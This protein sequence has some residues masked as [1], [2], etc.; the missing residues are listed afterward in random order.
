MNFKLVFLFCF[1]LII[2]FDLFA[3]NFENFEI[4][5]ENEIYI[6]EFVLVN[7][8]TISQLYLISE[9][10]LF[11]LSD[12]ASTFEV[13]PTNEYLVNSIR[14]RPSKYRTQKNTNKPTKYIELQGGYLREPNFLLLQPTQK[15]K[16]TFLIEPK[17]FN[18]LNAMFTYDIFINIHHC[19]YKKFT[20]NNNELRK[21]ILTD[22]FT[23]NLV[24]KI[25][26]SFYSNY[27]SF[28]EIYSDKK[29]YF[30]D[31]F[32]NEYLQVYKLSFK[33]ADIK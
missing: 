9:W 20:I 5:K 7:K 2:V 19:S 33:I 26:R 24:F 1:V 14:I 28:G 32:F 15:Q 25:Y 11:S 12:T 16:I 21:K 22:D 8:D 17:V 29:K 4:R 3:T 10:N 23:S 31:N 30:L 18:N 13:I 27:Y 6:I